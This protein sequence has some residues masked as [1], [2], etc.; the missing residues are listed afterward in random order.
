MTFK[1]FWIIFGLSFVTALSGA[2]AP[3]PLLT[4]TIMKSIKDKKKGFL[5]GLWIISGHALLES[6]I[7]ILLLLGFSFILQNKVV[8]FIISLVG[9]GFL[10]YFGI[11]MLI[12]ISR[13]EMKADFLDT[14]KNIPENQKEHGKKAFNLD[15]PILGGILVSMSNPYWWMWWASIG[16]AFLIKW[17]ISLNNWHKMLAFFIGHEAGDLIWYVPVA[18]L[19]FLGQRYFNRKVYYII[20]SICGVFLVIF[21][22]YMGI[23][24][25]LDL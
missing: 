6:V 23:S 4:Y 9:C 14:K 25:F 22:L 11:S 21:G 13:G 16:S 12:R 7:L 3:G 24:A 10:L 1:V 5:M 20:L 17:G 8:R 15:N 18:I 19:S 2:M